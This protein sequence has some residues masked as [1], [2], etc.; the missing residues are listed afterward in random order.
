MSRRHDE[1]VKEMLRRGYNHHSPIEESDLPDFSYL[2]DWQF[3]AKVSRWQS[4]C[5]LYEKCPDCRAR[6]EV[7]DN[8]REELY[9]GES[10]EEWSGL[11]NI[12]TP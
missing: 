7:F 9:L 2:P 8:E 6:I 3:N 1:L 12:H 11:R 4:L 5:E 10:E